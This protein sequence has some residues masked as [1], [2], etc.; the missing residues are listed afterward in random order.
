MCW[1][2]AVLHKSAGLKPTHPSQRTLVVAGLA[3]LAVLAGLAGLA[4]LNWRLADLVGLG[5]WLGS[6]RTR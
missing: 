1:K 3:K 4:R 6:R 2:V 5:S